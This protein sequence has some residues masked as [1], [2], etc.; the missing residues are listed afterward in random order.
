M[1][2]VVVFFVYIVKKKMVDAIHAKSPFSLRLLAS[3]LSGKDDLHLTARQKKKLEKHKL[4]HKGII[5]KFSI[6]QLTYISKQGGWV[7]PLIG[8]VLGSLLPGLLSTGVKS[9]SR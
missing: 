3:H 7:L 9:M 6:R 1:L 2:E 8:S 5:L 4:A